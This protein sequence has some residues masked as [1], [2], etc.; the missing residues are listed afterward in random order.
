M[1][2]W[3]FEPLR[4]DGVVGIAHQGCQPLQLLLRLILLGGV[5]VTP[6]V[7]KIALSALRIGNLTE[8]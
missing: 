7:P 1:P 3:S 2:D 8:R 6:P 4:R 5:G